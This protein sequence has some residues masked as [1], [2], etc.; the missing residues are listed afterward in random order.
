MHQ[1]FCILYKYLFIIHFRIA[2]SLKI[3]SVDEDDYG[4][5]TCEAKN[6]LGYAHAEIELFGKPNQS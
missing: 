6:Q 3:R 5:Y 4:T 2:L 1:F